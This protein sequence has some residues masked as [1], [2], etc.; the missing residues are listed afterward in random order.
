MN[1]HLVATS[2]MALEECANTCATKMKDE[3]L[4][5][6]SAGVASAVCEC[7]ISL[8]F[9]KFESV[10]SIQSF[11]LRFQSRS[12]SLLICY[13]KG[14]KDWEEVMTWR[15]LQGI[16]GAENSFSPNPSQG[17]LGMSRYAKPPSILK[18]KQ[19]TT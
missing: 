19:K 5:C 12:K 4:E 17:R 10:I 2:T 15:G 14:K 3:T 6:H 13:S 1:L 18:S 9:L 11:S 16:L 8:H 7:F